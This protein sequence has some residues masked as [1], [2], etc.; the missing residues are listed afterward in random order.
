MKLQ[1]TTR[2]L[3][4]DLRAKIVKEIEAN[5]PEFY[6]DYNDSLSEDQVTKILTEE[7]G[8]N[9]VECEIWEMN[10][11]YICEL[12]RECIKNA[13]EQFEDEIREKVYP[14]YEIEFFEIEAVYDDFRDDLQDYVEVDFNFNDLLL[15]TGNVPVRVQMYSNYDC[16]N[17]HHFEGGTYDMQ[18]YFGDM[19]DT[20]NLNPKKVKQTLLEAGI[21]VS[22]TWRD[23]P[24]RNGKEL[25]EYSDLPTELVNSSCGANLLTFVAKIDLQDAIGG[26]PTK[27]VIPKG[28]TCGLF[29]SCY[30]G[31]SM[32]E[33]SLIRDM[34]VDTTKAGATEY[35]RL[36]LVMDA[37]DGY[38]I[39]E[40][41]G[42]DSSLFGNTIKAI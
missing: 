5:Q 38:S 19:V 11:D 17:S 2:V 22:G 1:D 15:N 12:E 9:D 39:Q 4:D 13:L 37:T 36:G 8:L 35:D 33:M 16:M 41:F 14:D 21:D 25:I 18:S 3:P 10:V 27:F 32:I 29:S 40:V 6:W 23:K 30:G 31:G 20:L 42:C 24:G 26:L 34:E 28:N 7:N